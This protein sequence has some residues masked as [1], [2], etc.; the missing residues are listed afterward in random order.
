MDGYIAEIRLFAPNFAPKNWAYCQGQTLPINQ[1]Q[2]LFSLLG[3]TYGGNGS[4]TFMLPDL[5]GRTAIG[6]G[7]GQG[8]SN[9]F[10]GLATGSPTTTLN[11][12]NLPA[13]NHAVTGT[14]TQASNSSGANST[15]PVGNYFANDGSQKY[16]AQNDG[17]TMKPA[18]LNLS[19]GNTGRSNAIN[20]M[21]PYLAINYIICLAGIFPPRN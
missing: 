20:N 4:T 14:I 2:A 10:L 21:M 3:T 7:Q 19:V 5:R 15:S 11:A 17:V 13:H 18:T 6:I 12:N 9:Y 16:D 8:L 1:N